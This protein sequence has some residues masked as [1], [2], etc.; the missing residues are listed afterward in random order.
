VST[1]VNPVAAGG[2]ILYT[3]TVGNISNVAV[4]GITLN[5]LLPTGVQF[6]YQTDSAPDVTT[7]C[8]SNGVCSAGS[9]PT[10]NLGSL[11]AGSTLTVV[12][13]VAVLTTL[14]DGDSIDASFKL[15]ATGVNPTTF[16]KVVQVYAE[17]SAQL[18]TGTTI[19]PAT[20]GQR[21]T[22]DLDVGQIGTSALSN[23][24]L[25]ETLAPGLTVASVGQGG[26]QSSPGVVTW[27]IGS[28]GVGLA[29]HRTVDVTVDGNVPAGAILTTRGTLT[30]DGGLAVDA[31]ADYAIRV[32]S[33]TPYL[34]M[35][36]ST[37][38]APAVPGGRLA[39]TLTISNSSTR[40]VDSVTLM[41]LVPPGIQ[42]EYQTDAA[43]DAT[44]GCS[45]NGNCVATQEV[46]WSLGTIAAGDSR[47]VM[48]NGQ[49][50]ANTVGNGNI[51]RT[52]FELS[53]TGIAEVDAVKTVQIY[54]SPGAQLAFGTTANP[55][56]SG[57]SFTY[58]LDIGQIGLNALSNA[59]LRVS[60]P[61]GLSVNAI[62]GGGA[63]DA[64][65]DVVWNI[66]GIAVGSDL[67]YT[68][69][70]TGNGTAPAAA[71]LDARATLTYDGGAE[72]DAV[73]DYSVPVVAAP[74]GMTL[75][76]TASPNPAVPGNRLLYTA[77][78]TNTTARSVDSV[79]LIYLVPVG[80]QFNYANDADPNATTGCS[81]NGNCSAG[82]EVYWNLGTMAAGASQIITIN[83]QVLTSLLGGS[84]I[85]S[86]FWLS[87]NGLDAPLLLPVV[88]PAQ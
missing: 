84:L 48:I 23:A 3:V 71:I 42:F 85:P 74:Q 25:Q 49:V 62:S 20:P 28:V 36:V 80:V 26:T 60:L 58:N 27:N 32:A 57:Q 17:S 79:S 35:V 52:L 16:D 51:V 69:D 1:T 8:A 10:W 13:N 63:Q 34:S 39:Y 41:M 33:A 40:S 4:S 14:G 88:V 43:P 54:D 73:T 67:H 44:T 55:V 18:S 56:T 61:A 24:V 50:L 21:L 29:V 77:T 19:N 7:G 65:G 72:V 15:S 87:A 83:A 2:R 64:S 86:T 47:T 53:G 59:V 38:P 70:V 45:S 9:Q 6:T 81:S 76:V 68:I 37:N 11:T 75:T 46:Y 22:L 12:I 30:Y 82:A 78:V 66:G 5:W 31:A